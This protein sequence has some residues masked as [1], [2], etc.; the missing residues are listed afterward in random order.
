MK[1]YKEVKR[2]AEAAL[3]G[4]MRTIYENLEEEEAD[5][6]CLELSLSLFTATLDFSLPATKFFEEAQIKSIDYQLNL[7]DSLYEAKA[8]FDKGD[9]NEADTI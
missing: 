3:R 2:A 4:L 1:E 8:A 9:I 7:S 6:L 5:S